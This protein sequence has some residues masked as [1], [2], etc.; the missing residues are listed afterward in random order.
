MIILLSIHA[1]LEY[2][3]NK[4]LCGLGLYHCSHVFRN[5]ESGRPD[6]AEGNRR[7]GTVIPESADSYPGNPADQIQQQDTAGK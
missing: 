2:T 6:T 1:A 3:D 4:C 5:P 7:F